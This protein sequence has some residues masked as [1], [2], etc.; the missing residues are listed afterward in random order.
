MQ[1]AHTLTEAMVA[2]TATGMNPASI[3]L[4]SRCPAR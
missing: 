2:T 4:V 3:D 1:Y